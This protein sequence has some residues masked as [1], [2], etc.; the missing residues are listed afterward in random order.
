[1]SKKI[2]LNLDELKVQSFVTTID[3]KE[4]A[5]I[6]GALIETGPRT[7]PITLNGDA[8]VSGLRCTGP[9]ITGGYFG[10]ICVT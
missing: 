4:Q 1:M 5:A 10:E 7:C 2:R 3:P 9:S 6:F 8:C